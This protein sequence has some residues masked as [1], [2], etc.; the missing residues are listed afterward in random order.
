MSR[1]PIQTLFAAFFVLVF[2]LPGTQSHA[3]DLI[4][5]RSY[6]EDPARSITFEQA[7][8]RIF[9]EY[10]GLLARG[11]TGSAH[12]IKLRIEPST[13]ATPDNTV[14]L[15]I[16]PV[17]VD[18]I[19]LY[20]PLSP[21]P[22][23]PEISG[24]FKAFDQS[25]LG[26]LSHTF[27]IAAQ[28]TAR[29][30]YLRI[31]SVHS[32]LMH[33]EALTPK[34]FHLAELMQ[35]TYYAVHITVQII[36]YLWVLMNWLLNR[37]A[38][39]RNFLIK[40]GIMIVH[41][42]CVFGY[43]RLFF[44]QLIEPP[45]LD[46]YFCYL[47]VIVVMVATI[48]E[49]L[50]LKDYDFPSFFRWGIRGLIAWTIGDIVVMLLGYTQASL[51][52]NSIAISICTPWLALTATFIRKKASDGANAY[53]I[54]KFWIIIY[55]YLITVT[56]GITVWANAGIVIASILPLYTYVMYSTI[57]GILMTLLIQY[58]FKKLSTENMQLSTSVALKDAQAAQERHLREEQER[59]M[60]MFSHEIRTPLATIRM[61][62]KSKTLHDH[63]G[64][65][66]RSVIGVDTVIERAL[67]MARLDGRKYEI[68][69]ISTDLTDAI[70]GSAASCPS[71]KRI[72]LT[73]PASSV[74]NT[75][76]AVLKIILSNLFDNA[77]K[78]SAA[79]SAIK[80]HLT[81]IETMKC[82]RVSIAN[83]PR[84]AGWPDKEMVFKKFYR[85]PY[86]SS[87]AGTGLGL[88]VIS[89]LAQSIDGYITYDPTP[90]D[91]V[92][93]FYLPI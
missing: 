48:Y 14:I 43:H 46:L 28:P 1:R 90:T 25:K 77:C 27:I 19:E 67:Q 55:Y 7:Q 59:L 63:I 37:D 68:S 75:D 66:E 91:I 73:L 16:R 85:S 8:T 9:T 79:G 29:E 78:Y 15:R 82:F 93:A 18:Q 88:Y 86:A 83:Q 50:F 92:F 62:L 76:P 13:E 3:A 2:L 30:V 52:S 45:L 51:F 64:A 17:Y 4:S 49:Y 35:D 24:S 23:R 34:E 56:L 41:T 39:G 33:V 60:A 74:A 47:S 21:T 87:E 57:S 10:N 6:L 53:R 80:V 38:L 81:W 32:S 72:E 40:Q 71:P 26:S 44:D 11:F 12:W 20:D 31:T 36:L 61:A 54:S 22:G 70:R 58:R 42:F 5:H 69:K 65:I 84:K 89:G